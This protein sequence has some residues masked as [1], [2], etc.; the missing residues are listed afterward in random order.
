MKGNFLS[1][2]W[3][4]VAGLKPRLRGHVEL[5]RQV[6]RGD[7]WYVVQDLHSG[8]YHRIGPAANYLVGMMNGHRTVE[9]LWEAACERFPEDPPT[10]PEVI[11]LLSQ[12]HAS[13]LVAGDA[14]PDIAELGR[15][16]Y[17]QSRKNLLARIRNP[18]AMRFALFDPDGILGATLWI[19]RPLFTLLGFLGWLA[20]VGTGLTLASLHWQPLTEGIADRVLSG[21]NLL[22]IALAY[23]L[24]KALHELGHAYATKVWGGEVHEVGVM[25]LVLIPVPYVDASA[26]VAFPEKWRRAVVGGGGIMVELALA[27]LATIFWVNAEPGLAR[28]FAFNVML[29]GGVSTLL[30]NGNPLLRFDGYFILTDLIEVTNLAA[31]ANKY[32]WYV[33]QRY[34]LGVRQAQSPV[35]ARGERAWFLIYSVA[36]FGYRILISFAISLFIASKLFFVGS[37]LA[38]WAFS[39]VFVLPL[40]K[41]AKFLLFAPALRGGRRR[42][43][44]PAAALTG[45]LLWLV[46]V[47]PLPWG[48]VAEGV[49]VLEEAQLIR[50]GTDGFIEEV[51]VPR[52]RVS[53]GDVV[54][55]IAEPTLEAEAKLTRVQREELLLRLE[56]V[57]GRNP[58]Q[59]ASL[60]EQLRFLDSRIAAQDERR[61]ALNV[62][63][64]VA[65]E[66]VLPGAEDLAGHFVA[67]GEVLGYV[68]RGGDVRL[69]VAVPQGQ[70]ELV[71]GRTQAAEVRFRRDAERVLSA[72]IVSAAPES[73][74]VLPSPA[75]STEAGG[76][77]A[78]DPTDPQ[79]RRTLESL[80]TFDLL[81]REPPG[82]PMVGERLA[83]RFDHGREPVASRIYRSVR[84]LFL[85]QFD[86]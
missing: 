1:D 8:K 32:F 25:F 6:F 49:V 15:R 10:Q 86:V 7:T 55:R 51:P 84:Q 40:L 19:V 79:R 21:Q 44:L 3:Y 2:D 35:T 61:A 31:R 62:T 56:A 50:A 14:P 41:G 71:R 47:Q 27:A 34:L 17:Q 75:L 59:V 63:A 46:F 58:V 80:F 60:R 52:G 30:F 66:A 65:G 69:R 16:H 76:P 42:A 22:L 83:V 73:Q 37:I 24:I 53:P 36:A 38:I 64:A 4:R 81:L 11:H 67:K 20:L 45:V 9:S 26:S 29:I 13:D 23:P 39:S 68:L 18:L 5:H 43:L 74:A 82:V 70:A 33:V 77:F 48:T 85:R 78:V 57:L 12:L 54:I 28:A 72:R